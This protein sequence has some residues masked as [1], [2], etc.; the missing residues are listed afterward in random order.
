MLILELFSIRKHRNLYIICSSWLLTGIFICFTLD[1]TLIRQQGISEVIF[2]QGVVDFFHKR[3]LVIFFL[4]FLPFLKT[5]AVEAYSRLLVGSHSRHQRVVYIP[6]CSWKFYFTES[7][8]PLQAKL[9]PNVYWAF[10]L[11]QKQVCHLSA[12]FHQV[13]LKKWALTMKVKRS[14]VISKI[15]S[16]DR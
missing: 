16:C 3:S 12:I 2:F 14:N 13:G 8:S 15:V 7:R 5:L 1:L 11:L 4:K 6:C 10:R 9:Q